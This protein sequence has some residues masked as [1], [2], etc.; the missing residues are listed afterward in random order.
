MK[1]LSNKPSI[2]NLVEICAKKGI[3]Q[4]IISPGSRNAPLIIS[5]SNHGSFQCLSISD[6]RVAGFFALG[7]AQQTRKPVIITCTSGTASLNF[8]P[9][10]AEAFYQK[11]PLLILT[12]DRPTE[13]IHQGEG[14]SIQQRNVFAN[15]VKR[16]YELPQEATD[17]DGL[18]SSNRIV[19]EAID[20]TTQSGGGPVH[21][22]IRFR[23]PLYDIADYQGAALPKIIDTLPIE[24]K[25]P[26]NQLEAL[27]KE[28]R[29]AD[30]KMILCGL[31]PLEKENRLNQFL[32]KINKDSSVIVLAETTANIFG[33]KFITNFDG[34]L[35]TISD[36]EITAFQPD[37]LVTI[38]GSFISK[39][40]KL[41]LRKHQAKIHWHFENI[42]YH[43]DT[44][45]S[46]NHTIPLN[47]ISFFEQLFG[48]LPPTPKG[49]LTPTFNRESF[50]PLKDAD[51]PLGVGGKSVNLS[52]YQNLW[53]KRKK[54]V[55][56]RQ[57]KY[58]KTLQWSDLQ[59][60]NI[61]LPKLPKGT[62]LHL[63]N[64]TPVRYMQL[65]EPNSAIIYNS[66]RGVAGIDG[67]TSTAVGAAFITEKP[68]TII[69]GDIAFFYDSNAFWHSHLS[70]KLRVILINNGGG[71]IFRFI[72][73]PD[74]TEQ[75]DQYFETH[76]E[77]SAKYIAKTY[78]LNYFVAENEKELKEVLADFYKKQNNNHPAI[79]EV[80][81]PR[82]ESAEVWRE[83]YKVLKSK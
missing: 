5:F 50:F 4:V 21:L 51:S 13:W 2:R 9:A 62:N 49:E 58:L 41:F 75:L 44:F 22:N 60:F 26:E 7:I 36:K 80:N 27:T 19:C 1:K 66:N 11:I 57:K 72:K 39:K 55:F 63:G 35:T 43:L 31:L 28:W 48:Y 17:K 81:T 40:I 30:K 20:Q 76:H 78:N 34:V 10:I 18:W 6:E 15:Y 45:Q 71:N 64:S 29:K 14:Q 61:I 24:K 73:G 25:L 47:P 32:K 69:T 79:L 8:A 46:L 53:L 59:A 12:A 38:G 70:P 68:T 77:Q 23:E 3:K 54:K 67:C 37:L 82:L 56:V 83:Y 65:F 74:T 16:S 52:T 33:K 42:D